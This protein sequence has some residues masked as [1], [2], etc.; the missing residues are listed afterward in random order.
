MVLLFVDEDA[1]EESSDPVTVSSNASSFSFALSLKLLSFLFFFLFEEDEAL[2]LR[3][4]LKRKWAMKPIT[5]IATIPTSMSAMREFPGVVVD[6]EE[7]WVGI[8]VGGRRG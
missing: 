2:D 8:F 7:V 5:P 1:R 4:D 6:R 3:L